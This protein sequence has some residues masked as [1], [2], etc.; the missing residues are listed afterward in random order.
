MF[1]ILSLLGFGTAGIAV[2]TGVFYGWGRLTRRLAGL[3]VGTWP[4]SVALGLAGCVSLGGILNLCRLAYP[5]ALAAIVVAGLALAAIAVRRDGVW[6]RLAPSSRTAWAWVA[7]V[8]ALTGLMIATQLAPALYNLYDDFQYFFAHAVRMV[9]TGTL[10]GSPL[11][12]L[13]GEGL[14]GQAFLQG[15]VI[16]FFPLR[17]INAADAV[18]CFFLCMALAGSP[19]FGRPALWPAALVGT[20]AVFVI[21]PQF[22]NIS[23]LYSTAALAAA[24]T[25][26]SV[27][28]RE[29]GDD[30]AAG[31]R[32]AAAPALFY[33]AAVALKNTGLVFF[34]LQFVIFTMASCW[35][36]GNWRA[37]LLHAGRIAVWSAAFLAPWLLL[38]APYYLAGL[39]HPIGAPSS[40]I[41]GINE[42]MDS[43]GLR[44]LFSPARKFEG[45]SLLAC[46]SL[47]LG[48]LLCSLSAALQARHDLARRSMLVALAS[49]AAAGATSYF[50][51]VFCG[52]YLQ[53]I[54]ST[55]RY[56]MPVLIGVCSVVLPL[57]ALVTARRDIALCATVAV[58]LVALFAAPMRDRVGSLLHQRAQLTY[59]QHWWPDTVK[60]N[61]DYERYALEGPLGADIQA[62]Q[63]KI[64]PGEA[65]LAW[66]A[67]PFLLDYRRNRVVDMNMAGMSQQW[68][69]I[70][71]LRYILWQYHGMFKQESLQKM[72]AVQGRRMGTMSA[73]AID[74]MLYLQKIPTSKIVADQ[75]DIFLFRVDDEIAPPPN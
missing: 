40:P 54:E 38:F 3:P 25:I 75:D 29:K 1:H 70:P 52:P 32:Q 33:A 61:I 71:Q 74:V 50:F 24:L 44:T 59:I 64:P 7:V 28:P 30:V 15:F 2:V 18:F 56:S 27:D 22:V 43:P 17:F 35:G 72:L 6:P 9:E 62:L 49:A 26:F 58:L 47:A 34:G 39:T 41:P 66:T 23:S 20:L 16:G 42:V 12:A 19:A 55:V 48:L 63:A 21:Y 51:W 67:T 4:L 13:G 10:Y 69:R 8:A 45:A 31:W 37:G 68:G 53:E 60:A 14:G 11:N 57:W 65:I 73:R 36:N 46:T 5:A